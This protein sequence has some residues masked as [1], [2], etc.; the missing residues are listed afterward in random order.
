M[1]REKGFLVKKKVQVK[2][3]DSGAYQAVAL[4]LYEVAC[5]EG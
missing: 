4:C 1:K 3:N 2:P 5:G